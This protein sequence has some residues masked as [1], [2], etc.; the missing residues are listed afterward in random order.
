[1]LEKHGDFL[2][3]FRGD[4]VHPSTL[5]HLLASSACST[6]SSPG[7]TTRSRISAACIGGREWTIADFSHL[8]DA[9]D[10]IAMMPQWEFL[11]FVADVARA[12][13]GFALRMNAEATGLVFDEAAGS[14]GSAA[15]R[16][17]RISRAGSSSPPTA[18]AR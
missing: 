18:G 2:R 1:M 10:F 5:E 12:I 3:D 4:T 14:P 11:D 7:R 8:A 13:R 17:E 9:G 16:Q 15:G 6:G